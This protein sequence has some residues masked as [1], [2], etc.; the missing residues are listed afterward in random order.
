MAN[1][2]SSKTHTQSQL[3][4]YANQNNPNNS[5]YHANVKN[6]KMMKKKSNHSKKH[7]DNYADLDWYQ[8]SNP[9][10]YD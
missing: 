6:K 4:D 3:N 5:A 8:I 2:V 1:K 9:Y 10:D 7:D